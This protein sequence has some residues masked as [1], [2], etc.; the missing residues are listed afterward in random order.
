MQGKCWVNQLSCLFFTRFDE[1]T[2]HINSILKI[3]LVW[4][5]FGFSVYVH[6]QRGFQEARAECAAVADVISLFDQPELGVVEAFIPF[7]QL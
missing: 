7:M 6:H 1:G 5:S 2:V 3:L 4:T